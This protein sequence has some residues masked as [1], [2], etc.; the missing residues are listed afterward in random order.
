[1]NIEKPIVLV[2]N[3]LYQRI[4]WATVKQAI[5]TLNSTEDQITPA[6]K[7]LQIEYILNK[8]GTPNL[9]QVDF[10]QERTWEEWIEHVK[11]RSWDLVIHSPRLSIRI[12]SIIVCVN[13]SKMPI[14]KQSICKETIKK[15]DNNTCQ[16]SGV[17]LTSKTFSLDHL[18]PTSKGGKNIFTNVVAAHIDI[19]RKKGNK[20]LEEFGMPLIRLPKSPLPIPICHLITEARHADHALFLT[21]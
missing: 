16:Y 18:N 19:N 8:D 1:M 2:L 9:E 6:A 3:R 7:A 11:V 10:F 12:P 20:T 21:K 17:V 4:G 13:Y 15:R 5:I 14:K